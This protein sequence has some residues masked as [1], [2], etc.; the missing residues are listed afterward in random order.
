MLSQQP[1]SETK[2][3]E[4][5]RQLKR[6]AAYL[7]NQCRAVS[8]QGRRGQQRGF[9]HEHYHR[10]AGW[11]GSPRGCL[12]CGATGPDSD[13]GIRRRRNAVPGSSLGMGCGHMRRDR[14]RGLLASAQA[15]NSSGTAAMVENKCQEFWYLKSNY[16]R[17]LATSSQLIHPTS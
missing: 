9:T 14:R 8:V 5:G 11:V 15:S 16:S 3:G 2:P 4:G 10:A 6:T 1:T 13:R 12:A 17:R 7:L